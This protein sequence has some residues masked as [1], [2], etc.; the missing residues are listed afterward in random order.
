MFHHCTCVWLENGNQHYQLAPSALV[1]GIFH[2]NTALQSTFLGTWLDKELNYALFGMP[3]FRGEI[4]S[5]LFYSMPFNFLLNAVKIGY[6]RLRAGK[7]PAELCPP[8]LTS[9]IPQSARWKGMA[10]G[11]RLGSATDQPSQDTT[12]QSLL[13]SARKAAP[14]AKARSV[15]AALD[16]EDPTPH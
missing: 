9:L 8:S 11:W 15:P 1:T 2:L 4:K 7:R 3:L 14:G 16:E 5:A 10:W 6:L 13:Y 12:A